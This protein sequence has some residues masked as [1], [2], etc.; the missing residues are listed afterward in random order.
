MKFEGMDKIQKK[1]VF[2]VQDFRSPASYDRRKVVHYLC[3]INRYLKGTIRQ[4]WIS[5]VT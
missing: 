2:C 3:E 4:L 5:L 1:S